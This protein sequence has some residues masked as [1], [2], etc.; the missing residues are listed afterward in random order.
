METNTNKI[1]TFDAET[2]FE[3][4][5][6]GHWQLDMVSDWNIGSNPNG[7]YLL[8][9][10]LRAMATMVP[11]NP[12]PI[13]VTTHYLRPGLP[14]KVAEMRASIVRLGRRTA[15]V[16]GTM[17]QDGKPRITCTATFGNTANG[18]TRGK[19]GN[20][21]HGKDHSKDNAVKRSISKPPPALP[22]PEQCTSRSELAQAVELPIMNRLDIRID[23]Q[24]A[25]SGQQQKDAVLTGWIRFKDKRPVDLLALI[26][27]CDAFPPSVF[28]LY[29]P[30]GWVPTIELSIHLRRR[31]SPGWIK[32]AFTTD[33]LSGDLF[34]E[35]GMLWD[36]DDQLVARSRQ[37]QMILT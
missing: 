18:D 1:Y 29:G 36:E 9:C 30:I 13:A 8:A 26:L 28:T 37:L 20:K 12:D 16:T 2:S 27:F 6:D 31:P 35:D 22:P 5:S 19:D 23:P 17:E 33:D 15:T 14:G 34:I 11:D 10:L 25:E 32:G 4:I 21:H 3:N 7:G 24:Y